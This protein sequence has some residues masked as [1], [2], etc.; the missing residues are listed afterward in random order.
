MATIKCKVEVKNTPYRK[1]PGFMVVKK[2]GTDLWYYATY[3]S[4]TMAKKVAEE[5]KNGVVLEV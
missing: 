2:K 3:E 5:L 4:L 1:R